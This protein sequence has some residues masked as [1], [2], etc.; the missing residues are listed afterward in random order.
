LSEKLL[1]VSAFA[2]TRA[3]EHQRDVGRFRNDNVSF[4]RLTDNYIKLTK[5]SPLAISLQRH[6][7]GLSSRVIT[8]I[9]ISVPLSL[10]PS[11]INSCSRFRAV[12]PVQVCHPRQA[13]VSIRIARLYLGGTEGQR[14]G[15]A[16]SRTR[17]TAGQT[18]LGSAP[19][20]SHPWARTR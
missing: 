5:D 3:A 10:C 17:E 11:Q 15:E 16:S 2:G 7:A 19:K 14:T 12:R 13:N 1:G 18:T 6:P 20:E 8:P 4:E 9:G